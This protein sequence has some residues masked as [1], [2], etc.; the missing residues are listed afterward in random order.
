[1]AQVKLA[2]CNT[3]SPKGTRLRLPTTFPHTMAFSG[4]VSVQPVTEEEYASSFAEYMS[5]C[6]SEY[7][8]M[9]ELSGMLAEDMSGREIEMLLVGPGTGHFENDLMNTI[10]P[11]HGVRVNGVVAFEPNP[12]HVAPLSQ[13]MSQ[14]QCSTVLH[15]EYFGAGSNL[16]GRLFDVVLFV[17][18]CYIMPQKIRSD[19]MAN[20]LRVLKP[21]GRIVIYN[22]CEGDEHGHDQLVECNRHFLQFLDFGDGAPY[23]DHNVTAE[24]M[25][26]EF[27]RAMPDVTWSIKRVVSGLDVSGVISDPHGAAAAD[28]LTFIFSTRTRSLPQELQRQ[29]SSWLISAATPD[30]TIRH[31]SAMLIG[32][33]SSSGCACVPLSGIHHA[34]A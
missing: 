15:P 33:P 20:A 14:W 22:Q 13:V 10:L 28:L 8:A 18:S 19:L 11:A 31:P 24:T 6:E 1:L 21:D 7:A 17:H 9:K 29:M 26:A 27:S 34:A 2:R 5:R 12:A 3:H 23:A 25:Q 16:S 32:Q 4:V 30:Q